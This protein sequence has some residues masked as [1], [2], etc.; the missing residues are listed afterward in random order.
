MIL[1][2]IGYEGLDL[3]QFKAHL[4]CH[5]VDVVADVRRLPVSRKKG[6]SKTSLGETLRGQDIEYRNFQELGAPKTIREE[7]YQSGD[8]DR[9]F[10]K[11]RQNISD[12]QTALEAIHDL[13]KKGK[14]VTLLC[15]ERNPQQCHRQVVA[16][17]IQKLDANGLEIRH[18]IPF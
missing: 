9:F 13:L 5:G 12:K 16:E 7:L 6:F 18:I 1:Y 10:Q 4:A 14:K 11:Y 15:F 3:K 17:E 8:Y 2:T